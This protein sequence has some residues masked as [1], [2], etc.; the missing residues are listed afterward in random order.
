MVLPIMTPQFPQSCGRIP[1]QTRR[2][3]HK[4]HSVF[5][6]MRFPFLGVTLPLFQLA[7]PMLLTADELRMPTCC[8][9]RALTALPSLP[10]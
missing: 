3:E 2:H 6:D 9:T 5:G 7:I 8:P 4:D 1:R 10:G